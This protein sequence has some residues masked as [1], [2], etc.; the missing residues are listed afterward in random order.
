MGVRMDVVFDFPSKGTAPL[1]I[2]GNYPPRRCGIATFTQDLHRAL[3]LAA[4]DRACLAVAV[5]DAHGPYPYPAEVSIEIDQDDISSYAA[6]AERLNRA[7]IAAVSLQ[8][9]FGIY[10]GP[11]GSHVLPFLDRLRASVVTTLH[12]VLTHPDP[13]QRRVMER[14]IARSARLVVMAGKG[15]EILLDTY[16]VAA[17]KIAVVPHG[18]PDRPLVSSCLLYTSPSPRDRG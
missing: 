17:D 12:T 16:G 4:P 18:I 1:A 3:Q 6:A 10:G 15:R 2:V 8:H 13:E 11:A 5:S 9:E 14:L 7:G